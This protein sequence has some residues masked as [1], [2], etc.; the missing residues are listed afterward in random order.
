M[1][2]SLSQ[3][4]KRFAEASAS[5]CGWFVG[6]VDADTARC[7]PLTAVRCL[8]VTPAGGPD[9]AAEPGPPAG[10]V[11]AGLHVVGAFAVCDGADQLLALYKPHLDQLSAQLSPEARSAG[12]GIA[13]AALGAGGDAEFFSGKLSGGALQLQ[14]TDAPSRDEAEAAFRAQHVALHVSCALPLSVECPAADDAWGKAQHAAL[15]EARAALLAS[16]A[17][18]A[19]RF[20]FP[21]APQAGVCSAM[22]AAG[23]TT[24]GALAGGEA[25]GE[26]HEDDDE[27]EEEE[28]GAGRK[29][30]G[31]PKKGGGAKGKKGGGKKGGKKRPGGGGGGA[32][33]AGGGGGGSAAEEAAAE[34]ADPDRLEVQLLWPLSPAAGSACTPPVLRCEGVAQGAR[35]VWPL[36]LED[37]VYARRA[38]P[39]AAALAALQASLAARAEALVAAVPRGGPTPRA[40]RACVPCALV[41]QPAALP[42]AVRALYALREEE[43]PAEQSLQPQRAQLHAALGLP[44]DRPLLRS[45]N[46]LGRAAGAGGRP[47][48][49]LLS[50]VHEGLAPSGVK[51]GEPA[52][53]QGECERLQP[54]P[55]APAL[56]S[57]DLPPSP[58]TISRPHLPRSPALTSALRLLSRYP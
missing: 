55:C 10:L 45:S 42:T 13:L 12:G 53:V 16:L 57:H 1:M 24:V 18:T 37:L 30:G 39:L 2:S 34:A 15:E 6:F 14:P 20:F 52:L 26:D 38:T 35:L 11:P 7:V 54:A 43:G 27:E 23:A 5:A 21:G 36:G 3:D 9:W 50:Y 22:D 48:P 56:T 4:L 49:G 25:G 17:P 46:A 47:F 32:A 33:A 31:K 8:R 44:V 28:E 40:A 58:P 51:A 41:F 19:L 29:K